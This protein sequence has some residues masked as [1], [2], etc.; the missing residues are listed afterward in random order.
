[1]LGVCLARFE[2]KMVLIFTVASGRHFIRLRITTVSIQHLKCFFSK[3]RG[4]T[5][6]C[7]YQMSSGP[8]MWEKRESQCQC[9]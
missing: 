8:A 2:V 5:L 6:S 1:M 9:F 7:N 3:V 4:S